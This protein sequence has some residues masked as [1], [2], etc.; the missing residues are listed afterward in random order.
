MPKVNQRR[1]DH[2]RMEWNSQLVTWPQKWG[3]LIL[4]YAKL[5]KELDTRQ[6]LTPSE[7]QALAWTVNGNIHLPPIKNIR[8]SE[9]GRKKFPKTAAQVVGWRA[10]KDLSVPSYLWLQR[11]K[12]R[13]S[14]DRLLNWP[15]G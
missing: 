9:E 2:I 4:E 7:E 11:P 3:F 14:I 6:K 1:N 5:N 12:P 8:T 13:I 15:V 10:H